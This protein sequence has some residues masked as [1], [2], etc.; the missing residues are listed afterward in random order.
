M[1]YATIDDLRAQ[2]GSTHG[3][4]SEDYRQKQ[5]HPIPDAP[6]VDR[7]GFLL[8]LV[9]GKRVLEFGASGPMHQKIAAAASLYCGVDRQ[10]GPNGVLGF[11]LDDV[12]EEALPPTIDAAPE[13]IVCGEVLEHLGNPQHFLRRLRAQYPGVPVVITVP[14]AYAAASHKPL[15]GGIENVNRD[16]VSW[17]SYRTL[18]TLLERVG[19]SMTLVGWYNGSP[20]TA[21][22][23]IA[24]A[25]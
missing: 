2:L 9:K 24:L 18:R 17:Y 15:A 23:L 25:E 21:E 20:R 7:A 22:G 1:S 11:D 6:V 4:V 3:Q 13:V 16:H 8:D 10:D 14:N 12:S 19:Y 5:L